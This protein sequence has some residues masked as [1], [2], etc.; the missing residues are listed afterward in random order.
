MGTLGQI[1][2][3]KSG[4]MIFKQGML[5]ARLNNVKAGMVMEPGS[6]RLKEAEP[7]IG[8]SSFTGADD[9]EEQLQLS[10][11]EQG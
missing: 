8:Q 5:S 3:K 11:S 1:Q 7:L 2:E 10:G 9:I 6:A 4:F